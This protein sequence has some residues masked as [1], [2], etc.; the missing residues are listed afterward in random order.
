MLALGTDN[1]ALA[2]VRLCVT[3][4]NYRPYRGPRPSGLHAQVLEQD[5]SPARTYQRSA[6]HRQPSARNY[7]LHAEKAER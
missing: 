2:A 3:V 7:P 4:T 1:A 5:W 6:D